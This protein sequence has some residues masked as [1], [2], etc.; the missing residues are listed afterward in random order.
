LI[1]ERLKRLIFDN[2][3]IKVVS[4]LVAVTLWLY[5]TSKGDVE[6]NFAVPLE[7][8]DVPS[9]LKVVGSVT[10]S[11]NVRLKGRQSAIRGLSQERVHVGVDLSEAKEGENHF[12]LSDENVLLPMDVEVV[13]IVPRTISLH[14]V[15]LNESK[16]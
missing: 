1:V 8:R 14:L 5:V 7:L 12:L 13:R 9:S 3:L 4:F 15:R 6:V 2:F 11:V 10:D 16:K